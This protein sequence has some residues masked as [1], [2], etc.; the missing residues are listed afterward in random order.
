MT[1]ASF[2]VPAASFQ[3]YTRNSRVFLD[4]RKLFA[5]KQ[6]RPTLQVSVGC[7]FFT[8][9]LFYLILL[10][11]FIVPPSISLL[12]KVEVVAPW[13]LWMRAQGLA[14]CTR[15]IQDVFSHSLLTISL[16]HGLSPTNQRFLPGPDL[17]ATR[18]LLRAQWHW[19]VE[20]KESSEYVFIRQW[21][22]LDDAQA[23]YLRMLR[24]GRRE[25]WKKWQF[26]HYFY[27]LKTWRNLSRTLRELEKTSI[28]LLHLL[29]RWT[30]FRR[31]LFIWEEVSSAIRKVLMKMSYL[32]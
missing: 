28:L 16:Y 32:L 27:Y 26:Y 12:L 21:S 19:M 7:F 15:C 31:N 8:S 10:L 22:Y 6:S 30:I 5:D 11:F 13:A 14:V 29:K 1:L 17:Y 18:S 3:V 25:D 4:C 2:I 23:I 24:C 20:K 9:L